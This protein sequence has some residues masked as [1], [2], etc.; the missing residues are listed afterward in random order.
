MRTTW[1]SASILA[2]VTVLLWATPTVSQPHRRTSQPTA[3]PTSRA[4]EAQPTAPRPV[5]QAECRLAVEGSRATAYCHNPYPQA[6]LVRLHIE[7]DRWWD[8]DVDT[9]PVELGAA[10]YAQLTSRCWKEIHSAWVSHQP[11]ESR[12]GT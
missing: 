12:A 1:R 10:G 4:A 8:I 6:D 7:C 9:A 3:Q 2:T 5:Y 11:T